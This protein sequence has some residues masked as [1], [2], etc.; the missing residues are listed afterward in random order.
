MSDSLP[1]LTRRFRENGE[2]PS[3][4]AHRCLA[5]IDAN[6]PQLGAYRTINR[7]GLLEIARCAESALKAGADTGPLAGI[8]VSIKDLYAVS[9]DS[10]YAG[11]PQP[12]PERWNRE[13]TLVKRLRSQLAPISG[14][15]HT[16]EFA[17]GGLGVNSHWGTPVNPWGLPGHRVPGGSSAGAGVSLVEGGAL[18]ALGTD[19]AGSVRV[20]ASMTGTVGLKTTWGRW[21]L[22]GIFPLSPT[23]DTA[24]LLAGSV[25]DAAFGFAA[26]DPLT[27][28]NPWRFV[29]RIDDAHL[30]V[31]G[32]GEPAL[33][34]GI[35]DTV[36]TVLEQA[37]AELAGK[38]FRIVD[39]DLPEAGDAQVL[40]RQGNVVA[41]ELA[42]FLA[43]EL[44]AWLETL[45]PVVGSRIADGGAIDAAEYLARR[46]RLARCRE[47]AALRFAECDVM[48]CATVKITPPEYG[49]VCEVA[50]YRPANMAALEN[51]CVA[52]SLGLCA[53]TVP[54]GLDGQ[55]MPAG[56]QLMAPGGA[57][58]R[59]LRA[60]LAIERALGDARTRLG[61]CPG[62]VS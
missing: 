23:L 53:L 5:A 6:E 8:P 47:G 51:T 59:L 25:I 19:T 40:L 48:V 24:G 43:S 55:G 12:L 37:L 38:G 9:G 54:V 14:K 49:A 27:R 34:N 58:E 18:L 1:A 30:P 57:E 56:L 2:S 17:F 20:P 13:G 46:R 22:D 41:A 35:D 11:S 50:G 39:A 42:E 28:E 26:L 4:L 33:W 31:L 62:V 61:A 44:P 45:D 3:A 16:V 52:N 10:C 36:A 32:R 60:G 15:T 7:E 21:P 29:E